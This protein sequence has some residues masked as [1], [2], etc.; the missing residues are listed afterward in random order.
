MLDFSQIRELFGY[1]IFNDRTEIRHDVRCGDR[2][3][4]CRYFVTAKD[5][6]KLLNPR[7]LRR[8]RARSQRLLYEAIVT[9]GKSVEEII[10]LPTIKGHETPRRYA[11]IAN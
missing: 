6:R 9:E 11:E 8:Y 1:D 2:Q 3:W 10:N 4:H 7:T 5:H